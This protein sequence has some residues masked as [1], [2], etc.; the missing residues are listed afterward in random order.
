MKFG[1]FIEIKNSYIL[2]LTNQIKTYFFQF[3]DI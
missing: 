1:K 3:S 2:K